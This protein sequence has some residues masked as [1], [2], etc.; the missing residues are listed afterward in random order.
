MG[1]KDWADGG[2]VHAGQG[3]EYQKEKNMDSLRL[4]KQW[5]VALALGAALLAGVSGCSQE[6]SPA[7]ANVAS[8]SEYALTVR[9]I[10]DAPKGGALIYLDVDSAKWSAA[11]FPG[12]LSVLAATTTNKRQ[13]TVVLAS[14]DDVYRFDSAG[15]RTKLPGVD[16]PRRKYGAPSSLVA[17]G[18]EDGYVAVYNDGVGPDGTAYTLVKSTPTI[19]KAWSRTGFADVLGRCGDYHVAISTV[20]DPETKRIAE[21]R[22]KEVL[23]QRGDAEP[24]VVAHLKSNSDLQI[25]SDRIACSGTDVYITSIGYDS[26][27]PKLPVLHHWDSKT[28]QQTDRTM[29]PTADGVLLNSDHIV[30][31][32]LVD[33]KILV[34]DSDGGVWQVDPSSGVMKKVINLAGSR[35]VKCRVAVREDVLHSACKDTDDYVLSTFSVNDFSRMKTVTFKGLGKYI[36]DM[37]AFDSGLLIL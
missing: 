29:K 27:A 30:S 33:S 22:D 13:K 35:Q 16:Y 10:I 5:G 36:T 28:W 24:K 15:G 18:S 1:G 34:Q 32:F 37:N 17:A 9:P 6:D 19:N 14:D 31:T 11:R 8:E 26:S 20:N 4:N 2:W 21:E 23:V 7:D 3:G 12:D 25:S